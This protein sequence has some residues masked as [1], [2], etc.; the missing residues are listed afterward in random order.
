MMKSHDGPDVQAVTDVLI[1]ERD[2]ALTTA[3]ERAAKVSPGL[4]IDTDHLA[5]APAVA[6]AEAGSAALMLVVGSRGSGAFTAL[7]LGSVSRYAATHAS[8]PV[9]VV[10][11]EVA[12]SH[13][14][15]AVGI[16]D[17]DSSS[18]ALTFAF[19]EAALRQGA[20]LVVHA[21]TRPQVGMEKPY[22]ALSDPSAHAMEGKVAQRLTALID[23]WRAKYPDVEVSQDI[24]FGH[25]GRALAGLSARADLVV[26][27]R[28]AAH[29]GPGAVIHAVLSHAHGPI[30]TVPS[31]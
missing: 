24:L 29:H 1:Q 9:V 11:D 25:P 20:L 21:W 27:G 6:V 31:A 19:E 8:C 18:A 14:Q 28:H 22:W 2:V 4:L 23:D 7:V 17:P 13:R 3:A 16:G 15:I 10:R 30:A 5:G 12:A 26:V